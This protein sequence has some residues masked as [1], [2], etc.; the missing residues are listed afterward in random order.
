MACV[1][2]ASLYWNGCGYWPRYVTRG[3]TAAWALHGVTWNSE[4]PMCERERQ[5]ELGRY[6]LHLAVIYCPTADQSRRHRE[7]VRRILAGEV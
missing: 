5:N 6:R 7:A 1:G 3:R 4:T 2:E